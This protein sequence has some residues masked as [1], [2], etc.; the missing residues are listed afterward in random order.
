MGTSMTTISEMILIRRT[1]EP[2]AMTTPKRP[3]KVR[4]LKVGY[5]NN[6]IKKIQMNLDL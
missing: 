2:Q 5:L 6:P 3:K 1:I 4:N